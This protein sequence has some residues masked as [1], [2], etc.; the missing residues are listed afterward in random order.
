MNHTPPAALQAAAPAAPAALTEQ[1]REQLKQLTMKQ[2]VM[3][4]MKVR[5]ACLLQHCSFVGCH[6]SP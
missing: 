6:A 4:F 5:R 3:L 2:P 1:Q